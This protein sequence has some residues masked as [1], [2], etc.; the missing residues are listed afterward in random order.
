VGAIPQFGPDGPPAL[1]FLGGYPGLAL[2][3]VYAVGAVPS[4]H[5]SATV[6]NATVGRARWPVG[7]LVSR[8][9]V[10]IR[11]EIVFPNT[12]YPCYAELQALVDAIV[13]RHP[14]RLV[15]KPTMS[16]Q[17]NINVRR[18]AVTDRKRSGAELFSG[19]IGSFVPI[20]L[21]ASGV[22]TSRMLMRAIG[23]A[24]HPVYESAS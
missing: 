5:V 12:A 11:R 16:P 17:H 1:F 9:L 4:R 14:V 15:K 24:E 23:V 19:P 2:I 13:R 7:G 10:T 6:G 3:A 21:A 8:K 18:S 22:A 20:F